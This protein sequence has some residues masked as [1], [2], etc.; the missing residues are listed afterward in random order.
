MG[1]KGFVL[2]GLVAQLAILPSGSLDRN[3]V[4]SMPAWPTQ[5]DLLGR[6]LSLHAPKRQCQGPVVRVAEIGLPVIQTI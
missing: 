5:Q 1:L 6:D 3:I 4:G 2:S